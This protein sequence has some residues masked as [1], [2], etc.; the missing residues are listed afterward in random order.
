MVKNIL[1]NIEYVEPRTDLPIPEDM[2][3]CT[4]ATNETIPPAEIKEDAI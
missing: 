1:E 4:P 2:C 3:N